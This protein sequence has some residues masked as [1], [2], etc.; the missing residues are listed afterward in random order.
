MKNK[1]TIILAGLLF[2]SVSYN[3]WWV[4]FER[5][6]SENT[7]TNLNTYIEM[8]RDII[9]AQEEYRQT[10]ADYAQVMAEGLNACANGQENV[11]GLLEREKNLSTLAQ[12]QK[13]ELQTIFTQRSE[14][15]ENSGLKVNN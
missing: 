1:V 5:T 15:A 6:G 3:I 8:S 4:G 13:N 10:T 7:I 14:F 11:D 9:L 12:Q 2:L